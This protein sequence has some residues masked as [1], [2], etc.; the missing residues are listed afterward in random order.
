MFLGRA[1]TSTTGNSLILRLGSIKSEF[2]VLPIKMVP[3]AKKVLKFGENNGGPGTYCRREKV[4]EIK[5]VE[6]RKGIYLSDYRTAWSDSSISPC[7][8]HVLTS[9]TAKHGKY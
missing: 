9:P 8:L 6:V 1:K 3:T 4:L 5:T 7:G 2:I